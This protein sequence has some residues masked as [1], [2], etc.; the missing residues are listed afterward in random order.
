METEFYIILDQ[1]KKGPFSINELI[2]LNLS[3]ETPVWY[4]ELT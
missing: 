1:E 4:S 3:N 2:I